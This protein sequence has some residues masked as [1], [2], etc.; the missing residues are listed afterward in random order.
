MSERC[1]NCGNEVPGWASG[2]CPVCFRS[3]RDSSRY[4]DN[5]I[6]HGRMQPS[7]SSGQ[8]GPPEPTVYRPLNRTNGIWKNSSGIWKNSDGTVTLNFVK[9]TYQQRVSGRPAKRRLI[10]LPDEG[11]E[12]RLRI[13]GEDIRAWVDGDGGLVLTR[14]ATMKFRCWIDGKLHRLCPKCRYLSPRE[15]SNCI[16]CGHLWQV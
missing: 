16:A 5:P 10:V 8:L 14:T 1:S 4:G 13:G 3:G 2:R 11:N 12:I 7:P 15:K 6:R 9:G